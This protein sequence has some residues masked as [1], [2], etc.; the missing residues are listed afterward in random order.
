MGIN[1]DTIPLWALLFGVPVIYTTW[2]MV[3]TKE[4]RMRN[5]VIRNRRTNG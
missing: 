3:A 1:P 5:D 4:R 2:F